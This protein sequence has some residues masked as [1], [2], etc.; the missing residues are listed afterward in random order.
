MH[1]FSMPRALLGLFFDQDPNVARIDQPF[2]D[3]VEP[4]MMMLT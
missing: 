3:H 2:V 4:S 1:L